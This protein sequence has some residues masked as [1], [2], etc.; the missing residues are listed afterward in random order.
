[1]FVLR[2]WIQQKSGCWV[3]HL[4]RS[5][6]WTKGTRVTHSRFFEDSN[7]WAAYVTCLSTWITGRHFRQ[8]LFGSLGS[9]YQCSCKPRTKHSD[10][11]TW[12]FTLQ[13]SSRVTVHQR[14]ALQLAGEKITSIFNRSHFRDTFL[15]HFQPERSWE[16]DTEHLQSLIDDNT[17]A[18]VVNNPSN[19]C[20]SV[21]SA[22]H[23]RDVLAVAEKNRIQ[24]IAD[25]IYAD[26]VSFTFL[27]SYTKQI[28]AKF[29]MVCIF[30]QV[31][32]GQTSVSFASQTSTVP[33][34]SCG[35]LTKR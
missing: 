12:I 24:V 6:T 31:F 10:S 32:P 2:L 18:I 30:F 14:E 5:S 27:N 22:E 3:L 9:L 16:V 4:P 21:Y 29:F 33:V 8:R 15:S 1:M 7:V 13:N 19:P 28:V 20:G 17:V 25:E 35:G 23:I 34:L 26:F 11:A